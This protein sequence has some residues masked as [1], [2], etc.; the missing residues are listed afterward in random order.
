MVRRFPGLPLLLLLLVTVT[1]SGALRNGFHF[2]DFHAVVENPH[3]RDLAQ[4]PSFFLDAGAFSVNPESAMYRPLL[5]TTFAID[6]ALFGTDAAGYHAVNVA[7]HGLA[8]VAVLFWLTAIGLKRSSAS[9]AAM[10]FA[11][12]PVN[13]EAVCYVSSRSELLM[14]LLLLM[15]T[16]M[17]ARYRTSSDRGLL[18]ASL[19][20]ALASLL[21]KSVGIVTPAAMALGD[22][23][24]GGWR[25]VCGGWRAYLGC[26]VLGGGYVFYVRGSAAH[27]LFEAPVRPLVAQLWTQ[28]KA[29]VYYLQLV[30]VPVRLNVEHQ[31]DVSKTAEP[32]ALVAILFLLSLGGTAWALRRQLRWMALAA[33]WWGLT[34]LPT[35]LVPLIVLVNEHRLYLASLGVILPLAVCIGQLGRRRLGGRVP[36]ATCALALYT[37][38]LA[39][40]TMQ[41]ARVWESELTLWADAA[42]KSPQMLRP[43]LRLADAL[44][45]DEE[46]EAAEAAYLRAIALRPSHPASRNNLGLFY[47]NRGRLDEAQSQFGTLL[48]VSPD[49]VPARLNLAEIELQHGRWEAADT[50]YDSAL[51]YDHTKGRAQVRRGQIE[52]RFRGDAGVALEHFDA[53]IAAGASDDADAHV[54]RGVALRKLGFDD[55]ALDAYRRAIALAP[56]RSDIWYNVGNLHLARGEIAPAVGAM[57]RVID[58][59]DDPDLVQ[60]AVVR[61]RE[62]ESDTTNRTTH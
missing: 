5:L 16:S 14:G 32:V 23:F 62:L 48:A 44:V 56:G 3:I 35:T 28:A 49:N 50:H 46:Y 59:G 29:H 34:L 33:G 2:D 45:L 18:L 41:R 55:L 52:L 38:G 51:I 37:I 40:L 1:Y 27:A 21:A 25:K 47:R 19:A 20:A 8:T 42:A 4:V 43:H 10:L 15:S 30:S 12:H 58:I 13:S 9:V 17:Y 6:R 24:T 26:A 11:V 60:S 53:G 7:V 54:G 57:Q 31:F 22:H 39:M 36:M 61:I